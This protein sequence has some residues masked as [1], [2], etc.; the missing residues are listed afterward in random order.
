M[1]R[2]RYLQHVNTL[3]GV[4]HFI[5]GAFVNVEFRKDGQICRQS[6]RDPSWVEIDLRSFPECHYQSAG[7]KQNL[8][9]CTSSIL[10]R[11]VSLNINSFAQHQWVI[12]PD[13]NTRLP[14]LARAQHAR[15]ELDVLRLCKPF[16]HPPGISSH[17]CRL[18]HPP[19]LTGDSFNPG[20]K[21]LLRLLFLLFFTIHYPST[22]STCSNFYTGLKL[23]SKTHFYGRAAAEEVLAGFLSA[24]LRPT[25][26][27]AT[28]RVSCSTHTPRVHSTSA[29]RSVCH[30]WLGATGEV[31]ANF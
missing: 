3:V 11:Q 6:R 27:F 16:R 28:V 20:E 9:G 1:A 22:T 25:K 24:L 7:S 10:F 29:H 15:T 31:L 26:I 4:F 8:V 18:V 21:R 17:G 5:F 12:E 23:E 30:V 14:P 13:D 2:A 19:P